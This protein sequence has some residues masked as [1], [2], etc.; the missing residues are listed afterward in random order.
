MARSSFAD[1][2]LPLTSSRKSRAL[3]SESSTSA[4]AGNASSA[5]SAD[6]RQAWSS[7]GGVDPRPG[8]FRGR[9]SDAV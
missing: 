9:P 2:A 6:A 1:G 7:A 8:L 5:L 3:S 4:S